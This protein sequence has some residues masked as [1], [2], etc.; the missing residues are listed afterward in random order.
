MSRVS[1]LEKS[2]HELTEQEYREFR[3][4][5]LEQDWERWDRQIE[6]DSQS[7]RLD[8]LLQEALDAKKRGDLT[9]L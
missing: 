1:E 2:V 7:G 9:D 8:F 6:T 3:H 4:R 5:F